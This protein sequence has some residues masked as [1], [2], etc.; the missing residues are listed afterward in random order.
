MTSGGIVRAEQKEA[1]GSPLLLPSAPLCFKVTSH[2]DKWRF[3][4]KRKS[5]KGRKVIK[6]KRG[7][8]NQ[9]EPVDIISQLRIKKPLFKSVPSLSDPLNCS[10]F[11]TFRLIAFQ[12][13]THGFG[14]TEECP[15]FCI[16]PRRHIRLLIPLHQ[17]LQNLRRIQT[18]QRRLPWHT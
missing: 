2:G 14:I 5:S 1:E 18:A 16:F 7:K 13:V 15:L 4:A 8:K 3:H 9:G 6:E 11:M 12:V 17:E 10:G